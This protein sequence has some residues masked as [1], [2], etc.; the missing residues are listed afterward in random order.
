MWNDKG[1]NM[2]IIQ[3][4]ILDPFGIFWTFWILL[5]CLTK[6][7]RNLFSLFAQDAAI[8][9]LMAVTAFALLVASCVESI[10]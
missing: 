3:G 1:I 4:T 10:R 8:G 7:I 9:P 2:W 5:A 6:S